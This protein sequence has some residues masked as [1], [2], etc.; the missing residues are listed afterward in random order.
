MDCNGSPGPEL[1]FGRGFTDHMAVA[2]YHPRSGWSAVEVVPFADVSLSPAAMV[3]HYGQAIF[4]GLKAFTQ[5]DGGIVLFRPCDHADRFDRSA[6]RLAM[7][8][9]ASGAL[10]EACQA[11]VRADHRWV[12]SGPG[13]SLYLRPMMFATEAGL[14]V[15]PALEYLFAVIA[16][17]VGAYFG[18]GDN[19]ITVWASRDY[20]RAAPGG[21]GSAKCA[22]NYAV[23][24]A[25]KQEAAAHGC[26]DTLWLDAVEHRWIEEL[27][28][29]N[30]VFVRSD[31]D[32]ATLVA[33][34]ISDTVLDGITR[35]SL[36]Q[37]ASQLR[38]HV[39]ERP[40]SI[41]EACDGTSFDEAF[42][43]GTAAVVAPIGT[44]RSAAGERRIGTSQLRP[45]T[46]GLRDALVAVQQ[47]GAEDR[48]G[49]RTAVTEPR[50]AAARP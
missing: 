21:T 2:R 42:A 49:W 36:L 1:G 40:V 32:T 4:E 37:L 20:T 34:P 8:E 33:P 46:V 31:P 43:C 18:R 47:G 48:F 50:S 5:P 30:V 7:P 29:M 6:R 16:S 38:Y 44:I 26:D 14:G 22:G 10:V 13:Q 15:R 25:A 17:P 41:E 12:P 28:G 9:L 11:L 39:V 23:S 27:G 35:R 19:P 3:F 45:V 24:L